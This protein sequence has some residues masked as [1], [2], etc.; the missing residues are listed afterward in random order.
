M[1]QLKSLRYE[2]YPVRTFDKVRYSDID[3]QGHINNAVFSVFLETG[4]V[5][6]LYNPENPLYDK[7]SSFVIVNINL[8]LLAEIK[9][10]GIVEIGSAVLKLGN[11][12]INFVQGLYQNNQL[13]ATAETIIVHV[14]N[15]TKRSKPLSKETRIL[16]NQYHLKK[17]II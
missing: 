5:E 17:E 11:S 10:P 12:S 9:W 8:S 7:D 14:D 4:R 16:L 6:V 2:D 3:R 15:T 13:V 1:S